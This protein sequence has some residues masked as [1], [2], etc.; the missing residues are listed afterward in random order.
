MRD[1]FPLFS[2]L[3]I[4]RNKFKVNKSKKTF[5]KIFKGDT[6]KESKKFIKKE[7]FVFRLNN[8]LFDKHCKADIKVLEDAKKLDNYDF[9]EKEKKDINKYI[10]WC[11]DEMVEKAEILNKIIKKY[12]CNLG[13]NYDIDK[14]TSNLII[15]NKV[16][17]ELNRLMKQ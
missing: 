13:S 11:I 17:Y 15:L 4:S 3:I 12:D 10:K 5:I 8:L 1:L 14:L 6:T 9:T 7:D 2:I 16:T